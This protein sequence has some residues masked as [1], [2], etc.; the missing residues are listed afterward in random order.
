MSKSYKQYA[1]VVLDQTKTMQIYSQMLIG[2]VFG[3]LQLDPK[4]YFKSVGFWL[5]KGVKAFEEYA[6]VGDITKKLEYVPAC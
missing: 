1:Q 4:E 5:G 6:K 3:L 2:F